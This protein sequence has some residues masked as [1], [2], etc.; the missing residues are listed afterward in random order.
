VAIQVNNVVIRHLFIKKVGF[1]VHNTPGLPRGEND[2][3]QAFLS[4]P[5]TRNDKGAFGGVVFSRLQTVF[6]A[7]LLIALHSFPINKK[8]RHP[9]TL[10]SVATRM[11]GVSLTVFYFFYMPFG[12]DIFT[13]E[14]FLFKALITS[15][16]ISNPAV[17]SPTR[18]IRPSITKSNF[19]FAITPSIIGSRCFF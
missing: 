10:R 13:D 11:G 19:F 1:A 18:A 3:R 7:F 15:S 6:L 12:V 2:K 8:H 9:S 16:V 14:T 17:F 5:P 4:F